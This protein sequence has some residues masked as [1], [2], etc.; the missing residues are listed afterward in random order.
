MGKNVDNCIA[1]ANILLTSIYVT[2]APPPSQP[3]SSLGGPPTTSVTP[4]GSTSGM[5]LLVGV[6]S[7]TALVLLN[8]LLIGCCLHRRT[9]NRI[10]RGNFRCDK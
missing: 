6:A 10:K 3:A 8:V 1:N 7:G 2:D 9:Q 5:L 4:A